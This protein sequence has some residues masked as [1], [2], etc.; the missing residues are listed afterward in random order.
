MFEKISDN[1]EIGEDGERMDPLREEYIEAKRA[2]LAAGSPKS[3]EEVANALAA[4]DRAE[5]A[6]EAYYAAHPNDEMLAR[7]RQAFQDMCVRA[8]QAGQ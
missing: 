2:A 8:E 7:E 1:R 4:I 6:T 5:S 3:P